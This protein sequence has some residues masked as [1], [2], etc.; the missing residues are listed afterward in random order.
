MDSF[1][2]ISTTFTKEQPY[3][4]QQD[5]TSL[6]SF[7]KHIRSYGCILTQHETITTYNAESVITILYHSTIYQIVLIDGDITGLYDLTNKIEY[8]EM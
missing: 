4:F 7:Y 1:S 2:F 3:L 6:R 8:K 5:I